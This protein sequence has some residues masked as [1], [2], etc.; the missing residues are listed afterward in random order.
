MDCKISNPI[1]DFLGFETLR[2]PEIRFPAPSDIVDVT[3]DKVRD[4]LTGSMELV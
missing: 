3:S 4:I 1:L 2:I